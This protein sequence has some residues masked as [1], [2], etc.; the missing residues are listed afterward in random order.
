MRLDECAVW[1][2]SSF[3]GAARGSLLMILAN[4]SS[5]SP[6][7]GLAVDMLSR[8]PAGGPLLPLLIAAK[9][10]ETSSNAGGG[11]ARSSSRES[12]RQMVSWAGVEPELVE[13]TAEV[14]VPVEG[15]AMAAAAT[16]AGVF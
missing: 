14:L 13:A 2:E 15:P 5:L 4:F 7:R 10:S 1:V 12:S 6:G 3:F 16:A 9:A 11:K 8:A